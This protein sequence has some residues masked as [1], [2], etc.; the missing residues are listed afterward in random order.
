MSIMT[1]GDWAWMWPHAHASS[2]WWQW[3]VGGRGLKRDTT[4]IRDSRTPSH[5]YH[6]IQQCNITSST[7][8]V[9]WYFAMLYIQCECLFV[10]Y[11]FFENWYFQRA[12]RTIL[13]SSKQNWGWVP[14]TKV[15]LIWT[16]WLGGLIQKFSFAPIFTL[17]PKSFLRSFSSFSWEISWSHKEC[18]HVNHCS[19]CL[20]HRPLFL[21]LK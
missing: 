19:K 16:D 4:V 5:C 9:S 17:V 3:R 10:Q 14:L 20:L 21:I 7:R 15:V 8:Q 6:P 1:L 11:S 12:C 18:S 2:W 13:R